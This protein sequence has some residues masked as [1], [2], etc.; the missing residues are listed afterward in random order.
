M[1]LNQ[2]LRPATIRSALHRRWFEWRLRRVPIEPYGL[3]TEVGTGRE[4][5][6]VPAGTINGGMDVLFPRRGARPDL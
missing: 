5:W 1:P 3:L 6:M 2:R 4:A